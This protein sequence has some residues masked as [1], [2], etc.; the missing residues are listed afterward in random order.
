MHSKD[1]LY[2]GVKVADNSVVSRMANVS[3]LL[4]YIGGI[5]LETSG[6]LDCR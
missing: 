5:G 2:I 3:E 1:V 4:K 6:P